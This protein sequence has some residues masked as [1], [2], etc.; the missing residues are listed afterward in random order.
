VKCI[1]V[2]SALEDLINAGVDREALR[3]VLD[4]VERLCDE[5]FAEYPQL[6]DQLR[7]LRVRL[8]R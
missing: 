5:H 6:L 7:S 4:A 8:S 2:L 1:K 3:R